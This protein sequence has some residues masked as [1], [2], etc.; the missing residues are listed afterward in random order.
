MF[1]FPNIKEII[2]KSQLIFLPDSRKDRV[3]T[4]SISPF[5]GYKLEQPNRQTQ[6]LILGPILSEKYGSLTVW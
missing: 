6:E 5:T 2:L 4:V 1:V 3:R